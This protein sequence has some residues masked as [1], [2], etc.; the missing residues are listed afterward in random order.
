MREIIE[1]MEE[2]SKRRRIL[3]RRICRFI[4][5]NI[6]IIRENAPNPCLQYR[7]RQRRLGLYCDRDLT[8]FVRTILR[9]K[10]DQNYGNIF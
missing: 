1:E 7:Y 9:Y 4:R 8:N 10:N 5:E 6:Q 2:V 3:R